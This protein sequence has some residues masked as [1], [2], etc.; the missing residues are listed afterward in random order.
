MTEGNAY[1]SEDAASIPT[2]AA[3]AIE[4]ARGSEWL[5]GVMGDDCYEIYL[6]Q[7]EREVDFIEA[8]IRETVTP[9]ESQRY[10][11]NF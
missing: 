5:K 10:L 9:V 1:E 11:A 7:A 3:T 4:L 2:D 8:Q 6:Q